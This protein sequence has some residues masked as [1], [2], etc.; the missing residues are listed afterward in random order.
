MVRR[1]FVLIGAVIG[2]VAAAADPRDSVDGVS[3]WTLTRS[4]TMSAQIAFRY[5]LI[6]W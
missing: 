1:I 3:V 4:G 5:H 2:M 6:L